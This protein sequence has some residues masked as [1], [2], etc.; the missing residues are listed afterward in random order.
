MASA[1]EEVKV[2][3]MAKKLARKQSLVD[4]RTR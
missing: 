2:S 3:P 1:V 4:S